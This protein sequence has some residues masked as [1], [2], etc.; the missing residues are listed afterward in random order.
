M[1][2]AAAVPSSSMEALAISQ[3]GEIGDDRLEIEQGL[4]AALGDLGLIGRVSGIPAGV[5]EDGA[6]DDAGV[7]V[8]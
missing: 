6:L 4:E 3:A 7:A 8:S 2:S 5:F 1:A